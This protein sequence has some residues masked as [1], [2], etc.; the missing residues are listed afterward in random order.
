MI[1]LTLENRA[2]T[3]PKYFS[4]VGCRL[5]SPKYTK[6]KGQ[7]PALGI[8]YETV[9]LE[10]TLPKDHVSVK[11]WKDVISN[12]GTVF[13]DGRVEHHISDHV[14]Q[15]MKPILENDCFWSQF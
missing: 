10:L 2:T 4:N 13:H 5:C 6:E 1:V 9:K 15:S 12:S 8:T 7:P 11:L 14:V 3:V